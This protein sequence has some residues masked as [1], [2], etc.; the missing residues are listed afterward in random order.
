MNVWDDDRSKSLSKAIPSCPGRIGIWRGDT[1]LRL[2]RCERPRTG[3]WSLL[4]LPDEHGR[5]RQL[6]RDGNGSEYGVGFITAEIPLLDV[7]QRRLPTFYN[8][9]GDWFGWSCVGLAGVMVVR[10]VV[11]GRKAE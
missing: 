11:R 7:G 10:R 5:L 2:K 6:F 1:S 3:L 8:Q 4:P 9:H